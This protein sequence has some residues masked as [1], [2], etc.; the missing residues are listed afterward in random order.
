[1]AP[2]YPVRAVDRDLEGWVL[3]RFSLT[4]SGAVKDIEVLE[5][6]NVIFARAAVAAAAKFKYKPR[7]INGQPVEVSGVTNRIIFQ[8]TGG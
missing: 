6:S 2:V 8:L 3:L 7:V 4:A 1:M 5:S